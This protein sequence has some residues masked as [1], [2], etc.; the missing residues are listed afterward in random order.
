MVS[1]AWLGQLPGESLGE[2]IS[3]ESKVED[4]GMGSPRNARSSPNALV[5]APPEVP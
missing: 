1:Q 2:K 5:P 4:I 3:L